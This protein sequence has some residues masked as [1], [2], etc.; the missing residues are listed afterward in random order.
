MPSGSTLLRVKEPSFGSNLYLFLLPLGVSTTTRTA[1]R[2]F[3]SK[4][5]RIVGAAFAPLGF[6][7]IIHLL[8]GCRLLLN[9][10]M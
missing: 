10:E 7:G 4:G 8:H 3:L 5:L 2:S 6:L 1:V 9:R